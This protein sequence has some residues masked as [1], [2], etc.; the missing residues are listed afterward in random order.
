MSRVAVSTSVLRWA[1]ERSGRRALILTERFPKLERWESGAEQPTL[2]Q[3]EALAK[4]TLTPLGYFF[5]PEPP[6]DALPIPEYRTVADAAVRRPSPDLLETVQMMQRRQAWMREFLVEE[7]Q[8]PLP[9]VASARATQDPVPIAGQMRVLLRIDADWAQRH[10]TWTDALRA[11][12]RSVEDAGVLVVANGIVGNNTHRKLDPSEFR[13]FVLVDEYAPLV[14]VNAADGTAA[15]MFTLAHEVAHLWFGQSGVFDLRDLQPASDAVEQACNRV[16]AEFLIAEREIRA[17]W[18]QVKGESD[19]FQV[20][21]R[22]FKVSALVAARRALDA[23]LITRDEF[24]D[25]YGDYQA[26]ERRQAAGRSGGGDFFA[27]QDVRVGRRFAGAVIQAARE[28]RLLY[29]D[30]YRLTGLYGRTFDRYAEALGSVPS[31]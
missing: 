8:P 30:A 26:D 3:L 24:L 29:R 13:G 11:L 9:F 19:P 31:R 17:C 6:E 27:N 10:S 15:Q 7:G 1:R 25:F 2:R 4:A 18:P 22:R 20:L 21:A 16:A 23:R 14:F 28:G 5:L 12:R